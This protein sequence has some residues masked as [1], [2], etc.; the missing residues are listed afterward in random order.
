MSYG[1]SNLELTLTSS[2]NLTANTKYWIV[3]IPAD[4]HGS[5][6]GAK[7]AGGGN[8]RYIRWESSWSQNPT[9]PPSN[10]TS[11]PNT[12]SSITGTAMGF[13][14][15]TEVTDTTAP[16][17]SSSSPAD[18]ATAVSVNANIVLNFDESVDADTGNITIK[19]TSDNST[20]ETIDVTG[21]KVSGSGSSQIT[22]NPSSTLDLSLI[23][24]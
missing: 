17:L 5:K 1:G 9:S 24:I 14:A 13:Y 6:L 16:T 3:T 7:Y 19:K 23:H 4:G 8:T 22:V 20:I 11:L 12:I 15:V 21:V 18:N 2:I 10:W